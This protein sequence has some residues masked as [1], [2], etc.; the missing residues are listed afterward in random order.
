MSTKFKDIEI[1]NCTHYFFDGLINRKSHDLNKIK[2]NERSC[3][4]ILIHYIGYDPA[5]KNS[6]YIKI[7][8]VNPLNL[9]TKS[10]NGYIKNSLENKYLT[11]ILTG[12][13]KETLKK[14]EEA[15]KQKRR[16]SY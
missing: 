2:I 7:R 14:Y 3:K 16:R 5:I 11:L 8:S 12:E 4:N 6:R 1:K 15:M 9:I 10:I 13:S